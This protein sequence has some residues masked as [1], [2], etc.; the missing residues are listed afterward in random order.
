MTVKEL[1]QKLSGLDQ[2][3]KVVVWWERNG[4]STL[5]DIHEVSLARGTPKRDA[6]NKPGFEFDG[7]GP[8]VWLFITVAGG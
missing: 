5:L 1:R 8:V 3:T 7:N 6:N 4:D 2:S